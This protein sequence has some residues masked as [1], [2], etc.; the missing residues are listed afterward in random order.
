MIL[1]KS[2][3][4]GVGINDRKFPT[5]EN[6]K[7][8]RQ[9]GLWTDIIKRCYDKEYLKN[10]PTYERCRISDDWLNYSNFYEDIVNLPF[11]HEEGYQL[12]KDILSNHDDKI[13]SKD[14]CCFVPP[15]INSLF[16]DSVGK[17]E[18]CRVLTF[19]GNRHVYVVAIQRGKCNNYIGSFWEKDDAIKAYQD[20]HRM[21][22]K[23]YADKY[24]NLVD[25][26]VINKL[27]EIY[28]EK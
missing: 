4:F 27:L 11:F 23:I 16:K 15:E 28:Y 17:G 9:Y 24:K 7:R 12:D 2:K 22:C 6:G 21:S 3:H 20:V 5:K 1:K 26:R 19:D 14:T 25:E 10:K 8:L 18:G 13:Y